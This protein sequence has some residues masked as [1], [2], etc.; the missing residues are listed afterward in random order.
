MNDDRHHYHNQERRLYMDNDRPFDVSRYIAE[1]LDEGIP[2]LVYN[3]DRDM[4]T[5][6]VGQELILNEMEWKGKKDWLDAPRGLWQ[7]DNYPAGWSKEHEGLTF[8]VI[9]NS[10]HMVPYNQ[11]GPAYDL[12]TR[13]LT[14]TSFIDLELPQIRIKPLSSHGS[15]SD[16]ISKVESASISLPEQPMFS[17]SKVE[18]TGFGGSFS[19]VAK[20]HETALVAIVSMFVGFILAV[21][22]MRRG[23]GGRGRTAAGYQRVPDATM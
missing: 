3:G 15:L 16:R 2:V 6:M 20:Q 4:T 19:S 7:V 9:Y 5:N 23:G 18:I 21:L 10:G 14:K 22:V 17:W 13:F 8:A 1:L 11:P 12:L